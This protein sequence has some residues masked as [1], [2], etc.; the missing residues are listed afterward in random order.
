MYQP[1]SVF[2]MLKRSDVISASMS[3]IGTKRTSACALHMSAFGG[4]TAPQILNRSMS[5]FITQR[6]EEHL[7]G[8]DTL[9][10]RHINGDRCQAT[11]S[12]LS[13]LRQEPRDSLD[14][15]MAWRDPR[16]CSAGRPVRGIGLD[17]RCKVRRKFGRDATGCSMDRLAP[18]RPSVG[19]IPKP[20][21]LLR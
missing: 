13:F 19:S 15:K 3:A 4:E 6:N 11:S 16:K 18:L 14:V 1:M 10:P 9:S 12:G 21:V 17:S 5:N 7:H 20:D 8:R 2:S